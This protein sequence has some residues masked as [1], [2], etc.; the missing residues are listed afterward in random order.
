MLASAQTAHAEY[1]Q[2]ERTVIQ[3]KTDNVTFDNYSFSNLGGAS[4]N[5]GGAIDN[6]IGGTLTIK[7]ACLIQTP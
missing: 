2:G 1:I 6:N 4:Y 7:K 3:N 5:Q